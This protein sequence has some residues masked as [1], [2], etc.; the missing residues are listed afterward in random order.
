MN[1]RKTVDSNKHQKPNYFEDPKHKHKTWKGLK[2][3]IQKIK[4]K[5]LKYEL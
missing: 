5:K 1:P 3:H 2:E 4:Y